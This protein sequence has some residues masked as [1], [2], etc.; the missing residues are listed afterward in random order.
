[1][2][3][4]RGT[5]QPESAILLKREGGILLACDAIQHYGDYRHNNLPAR[6]VMPFIGFPQ[7]TIIGPFWMK[8]MTPE[9][10][11]L[12][13]EFER[14]LQWDFDSL[15][16]A[17]GSYLAGGAHAAVESALARAYPG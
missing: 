2:F 7:T 8:L 9:G 1:L 15:L 12:K 6:L 13:D 11:S 4:F 10:A 3:C 5:K 17:H 16:S 14:L